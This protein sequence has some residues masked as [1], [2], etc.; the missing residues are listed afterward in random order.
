MYPFSTF[1]LLS[2]HLMDYDAY[3]PDLCWLFNLLCFIYLLFRFNLFLSKCW[4]LLFSC[5]TFCIF[6]AP[7]IVFGTKYAFN[8]TWTEFVLWMGSQCLTFTGIDTV[9]KLAV[10]LWWKYWNRLSLH[11]IFKWEPS[12]IQAN[13][14][15]M[16][17][18]VC[19][20]YWWPIQLLQCGWQLVN[21]FNL[22][23]LLCQR[24]LLQFWLTPW[25]SK[26]K[27]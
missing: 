19:S 20:M 8:S 25:L 1:P 23:V 9:T 12:L 15:K 7:N 3:I 22:A 4:V 2:H 18:N 6:C 17:T 24:L 21:I 11:Q 5:G 14:L 10:T 16:F 26:F 13:I 27:D